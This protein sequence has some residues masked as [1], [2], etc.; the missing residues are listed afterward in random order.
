MLEDA[1]EV[2]IDEFSVV[3]DIIDDC[4]LNLTRA[5]LRCEEANLVVKWRNV[6]SWLKRA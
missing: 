3:G 2:Y 6:I 5:L 1:L 4:L